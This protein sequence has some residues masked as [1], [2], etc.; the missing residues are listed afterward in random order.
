MDKQAEPRGA[1]HKETAD[2]AFAAYA[3]QQGLR[4]V[5]AREWR[6]GG[7]GAC[8][9]HFQFDDPTDRWDQLHVDFANS[10][11]AAFDAASRTLKKLCK[12]GGKDNHL[13]R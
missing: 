13:P 4:V 8:E 11:S 1:R 5:R 10:E 12:R 2:L 7:S 6:R 9:Y 3:L